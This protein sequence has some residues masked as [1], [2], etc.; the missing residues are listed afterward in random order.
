MIKLLFV[1]PLLGQG[2]A[3]RVTVKVLQ[4]L[5]RGRFEPHLALLRAE[6]VWIDRLP[7][8]V[9]LH[10]LNVKQVR[11][12]LPPLVSLIRRLKPDVVFSTASGTNVTTIAAC[13]LSG[14]RPQIVVSER[15]ILLNGGYRPK[16]VLQLALKRLAY[17]FADQVTALSEGVADD[18]ASKL[19]LDRDRIRVLYNPLIDDDLLQKSREPLEHAWLQPGN[20]TIVTAG[21]LVPWKGHP[22]TIRAFAKIRQSQPDARLIILGEGAE[23]PSLEA[24]VAKLGLSEVVEFAGFQKNPFRYFARAAVFVMAS[25]NE[26][27]CNVLVEAMACGAPLVSTDCPSGPSEIIT[28]GEDGYLVPVGDVDALAARTGAILADSVLAQR[29][30]EA[31]RRNAWRFSVERVMKTYESV[32]TDVAA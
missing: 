14:C 7:A 30:A 26:G 16:I 3:D 1:R 21:R 5:D 6:G 12:M 27:L 13:R 32:V 2:G 19:R 29:L 24:L 15:N 9:G 22:E 31:G 20:R 8:D 25:H 28:E 23:R 11:A 17:H 10:P 4:H 18:L